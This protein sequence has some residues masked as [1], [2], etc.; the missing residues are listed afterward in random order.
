MSLKKTLVSLVLAGNI[1]LS[2]LSGCGNRQP[3]LQENIP[4]DF[5]GDGISDIFIPVYGAQ[6]TVS[7]RYLFIGTKE[8][9]FVIST[10]LT[11]NNGKRY[12]KTDDNV[13]YIFDGQFY[14]P[15]TK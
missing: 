12:F 14:R 7:Q 3:E 10:E 9:D 8:G 2:T 15:E 11:N 5:T 1:A 4:K 6:G 13:S